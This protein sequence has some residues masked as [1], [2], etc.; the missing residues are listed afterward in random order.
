MDTTGLLNIEA[1]REAAFAADVAAGAPPDNEAPEL[2]FT[3][4]Q[5]CPFLGG[6]GEPEFEKCAT[7]TVVF[8]AAAPDERSQKGSGEVGG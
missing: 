3:P 6:S 8:L 1:I 7:C 5:G 2:S 4:C